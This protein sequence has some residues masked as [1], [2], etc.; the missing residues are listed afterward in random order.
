MIDYN[1]LFELNEL[2]AQDGKKYPKKREL[3]NFLIHTEGKHFIGIIGPRGVGKSV[4]LKQIAG[5]LPHA[6]YF[7]VDS[8][9]PG[10]LFEIAKTLSERYQYKLLLFDE[11][12]YQPD[13]DKQLKKIY[14]FLDIRIIFSSSVSLSM[15]E[16]VHDLSRRVNMVHLYPF[17]F[18]EY[19]FFKQDVLLPPLT[20]DNILNKEWSPE[21]TR[22][23]Y[24]FESYLKGGL[25]PFSLEEIHILPLLENITRKILSK[26]IPSVARLRID[27]IPVL[28]KML[29]FIGKSS[30]D[31]IN[32]SS[33]AQNIGITKYKA[34]F[35]I[36]L[37]KKAFLLHVIFPSGTNVL[38]EPKVLMH[39]PYRLLY[40]SYEEAIGGVREDF[41]VESLAMNRMDFYYLKS[42]R[43]EK[44][45]DFIVKQDS[46]DI[47]VEI[48]GRGKGR[49]QF[50][51]VEVEKKII[52]S[53]SDLI[54]GIK[55]P[56]F[57]LGFIQTLI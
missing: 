54:E 42:T 27:E 7:S 56:L 49:E 2:A 28:E 38:K 50:K 44:T 4:I 33:L 46:G 6:F 40:K 12:H 19:I 14:D 8:I 37:L 39:L 53:H 17:S 51:G 16:A 41:V 48:G 18:R 32:Y 22:C 1:H 11:I 57:L 13:Y 24:L 55:R 3:Y 21:H 52:L 29:K 26:D 47:V 9:E 43:G 20:L 30:V 15:F 31:G 35:Y 5:N 10:D 34:E 36:D 23:E 45:P 25:Y